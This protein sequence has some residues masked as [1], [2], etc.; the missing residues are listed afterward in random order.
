[1][2]EII[3][4]N[5]L[6][7]K[8]RLDVFERIQALKEIVGRPPRLD[9]L[10][11]GEN[12]A[13]VVY[14]RNKEKAAL[15]TGITSVVHRLS[16]EISEAE[17]L[18][19]IEKLNLDSTVDGIL[20]Q[21]PLPKT[22]DEKRITESILPSKDVDG[23]HPVNLG[24]LMIGEKGLVPCTP[25]GCMKLIKAVLPDIKGLNALVIGRSNIVGKPMAQL[26]LQADCT[27]TIAHSKTKNLSEICRQADI[28]IAAVG[29]PR[30]VKA[31]WVKTGAVVID[32]GINRLP[33]GKLCGDVDF[34][35]VSAKAMAITPVPK[36]VGPMTVAMLMENTLEAYVSHYGLSEK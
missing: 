23:F 4:G 2:T 14:V 6:A 25:K 34:E 12:P 28:V 22:I 35:N 21:L 1:M 26:L 15:E 36:G 11:V 7:E 10:I 30:F 29:H 19:L 16:E 33:D 18:S 9:V 27:V 20:V 31:D 8:C 24:R 13:S 17:L 32:V 5:L 3:Y